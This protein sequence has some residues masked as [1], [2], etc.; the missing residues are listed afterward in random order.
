M[1]RRV[2]WFLTKLQG[3]FVPLLT[4]VDGGG[5]LA[6]GELRRLVSWV[7]ERGAHGLYPNGTTSE[8]TRFTPAERRRIVE[9]VT[10]E[11]A[12]RVPVIAGA[13]EANVKE[14]LA[15][16]EAYAR[17]G[18]RSAAIVAPFYYKLEAEAVHAYYAEIARHASIDITLYNIPA[19][20]SP[21]DVPAVRSLAR[22]FPRIIGIKDSSADIAFM[23]RMIADVRP[24]RPDFFFL[25]GSEAALVPMLIA[26]CDGGAHA[27]ANVVPELTRQLF[28]L[29]R[30][31]DL[32][33]AMRL[34]FRVLKLLDSMLDGFD[35]PDGFRAGA[36]VRGFHMGRGRQPQS[37]AQRT[38]RAKLVG[39][40]QAALA[41]FELEPNP[42]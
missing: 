29:T 15:A 3:I 8:F 42:R 20:A 2:S 22:E 33:A 36:E 28:D 9:I 7:I 31:G 41:K 5:E 17:M 12:G 14:T 30:A 38:R 25:T 26:G 37:Q 18:V 21:I 4:P 24:S 34:Q 19:F 40:V 10:D 27:S 1:R 39:S 13:A 6:E 32:D 11:A 16:C 35:F 23:L